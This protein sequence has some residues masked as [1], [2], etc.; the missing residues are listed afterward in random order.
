MLCDLSFH[1]KDWAM[2]AEVTKSFNEGDHARLALDNLPPPKKKTGWF[3]FFPI[4]KVLGA[5]N[6]G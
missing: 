2:A 1:L 5:S 6:T 3:A 4:T